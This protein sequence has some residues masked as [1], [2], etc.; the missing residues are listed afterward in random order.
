MAVTLSN[1]IAVLICR[2][3]P[4]KHGG[5]WLESNPADNHL[6]S[7]LHVENHQPRVAGPA[8]CVNASRLPSACG[9]RENELRAADAPRLGTTPQSEV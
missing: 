8:R 7:G 9:R 1:G 6:V 3:T 5:K 4:L 2:Q